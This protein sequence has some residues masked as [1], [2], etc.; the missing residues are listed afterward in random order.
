MRFRVFA[1]PLAVCAVVTAVLV[2]T[3]EL[4]LERTLVLAP[5]IVLTSAAIAGL[6]VIW[7]RAAADTVRRRGRLD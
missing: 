1:L 5:V 7:V 4:S 2:W 3:L 6:I